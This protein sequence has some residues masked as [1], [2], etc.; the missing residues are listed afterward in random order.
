MTEV[1]A[2][3]FNPLWITV[4]LAVLG[5]VFGIGTWVG[6]VNS[7]RKIF[8]EFIQ[9]IEGKLEKILERLPPLLFQPGSPTRL[10]DF[11]QTIADAVGAGSTARRLADS[12]VT[13][14]EGMS[15]YDVQQL[16]FTSLGN[17][18][19]TDDETENFKQCAFENG[20]SEADVRKVIA[21]VL[22]D[23][24]LEKLNQLAQ[25]DSPTNAR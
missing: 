2:S 15:Q 7:D 5:I 21:I 19:L 25:N 10:T 6:R 18:T 12:L 23:L 1:F 8:R 13:E 3:D 14:A 24:L 17:C 11:G 20:V 16:C 22:R 4:I 9:T